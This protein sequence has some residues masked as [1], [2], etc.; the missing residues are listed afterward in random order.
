MNTY[1]LSFVFPCLNEEETIEFCLNELKSVLDKTGI[2]YEIVVSD[3]GSTDK[4]VQLAQKCGARVV[5]ADKKGYGEAL[6]AGFAAARG[7]YIAFADIDGSYPLAYL[8]QM[9]QTI[10]QK[11]ADM[12]I[13]SRMTGKIEEGAMP[14]L[15][16]RL[17]TPVLTFLINL[18]FR[19]HLSDCNSGFRIMKK[20]AY[21]G[22][23]VQSGGMEFASELLIKALKNRASI[24]E[25]PAGLRPDKRTKKPHLK[26]WR[27]G[28]RHLLF[29][30]SESPKVF[31]LTGMGIFGLAVLGQLAALLFGEQNIFGFNVLGPHSQMLFILAAVIGLQSWLFSMFLFIFKPDKPT[32]LT[33]LLMTVKEENLCLVF[34]TILLII[35]AGFIYLVMQWA[36]VHFA[37]LN[38]VPF[39]VN[40]LFFSLTLC[41]GSFGL[42]CVHILKRVS[43]KG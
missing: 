39:V 23:H 13:A 9:Y 3:N 24:I 37:N 33:R 20:S 4:S 30:F 10:K 15:H 29:I 36:N 11:N 34:A 18:F 2:N 38:M 40:F 43:N 16:R 32:R 35:L 28:M 21:E 31:E 27:D 25:I 26:T 8:P 5:F 7:T 22:W 42:L 1:D 14:F 41:M 19:G 6:K 17:G 12:V